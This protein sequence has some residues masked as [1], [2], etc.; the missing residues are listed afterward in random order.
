MGV[1]T[2]HNGVDLTHDLKLLI[3]GKQ[4]GQNVG[5]TTS[6]HDIML[7]EGEYTDETM[8]AYTPS[9]DE[10]VPAIADGGERWQE[11]T[12]RAI[13][14]DHVLSTQYPKCNTEIVAPSMILDDTSLFEA[15][16]VMHSSRGI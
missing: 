3:Y 6:F 16:V 5:N 14:T 10:F 8:P 15:S 2:L 4:G 12:S 1:V 11:S 7:V 9:A 13:T